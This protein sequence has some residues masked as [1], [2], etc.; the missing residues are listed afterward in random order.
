MEESEIKTC[1]TCKYYRTTING[2]AH[3]CNNKQTPI[4]TIYIVDKTR[5]CDLHRLPVQKRTR[6][7][8][9]KIRSD[10]GKKRGPRLGTVSK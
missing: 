4:E 1:K 10:A 9:R 7:S 2:M 8:N 3:Y 6:D 5:V